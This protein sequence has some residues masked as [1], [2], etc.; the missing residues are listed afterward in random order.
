M[1][2]DGSARACGGSAGGGGAAAEH[3]PRPG[4][5]GGGAG[6]VRRAQGV[7]GRSG[8]APTQHQ[9]RTVRQDPDA[10]RGEAHTL[11]YI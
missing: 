11:Q 10:R 3:V 8:G 4:G 1:G 9:T 7:R 2:A 6:G 5:A